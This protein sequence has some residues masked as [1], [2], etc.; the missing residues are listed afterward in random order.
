MIDG[1]NY[2]DK[3]VKNDQRIYDNNRKIA[4]GQG[5]AYTTDCLLHYVYFKH[6]YEMIAIDLSKGQALDAD[7]KAIQKINLTGNLDQTVFF[8]IEDA[9]K[10]F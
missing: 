3:P 8:I 7:P 2:F 1:K 6:Y 5:D 10:P 4:A 9:K